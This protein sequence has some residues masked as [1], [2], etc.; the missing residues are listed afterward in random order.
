MFWI[1]DPRYRILD[2]T[3]A[4]AEVLYLFKMVG[5]NL[6]SHPFV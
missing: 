6:L 5:I 1:L 2:K 3:S 4:I